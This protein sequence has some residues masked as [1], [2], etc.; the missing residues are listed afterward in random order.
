MRPP[1]PIADGPPPPP[2]RSVLPSA[3]EP[4]P[5]AP[6]VEPATVQHLELI[7]GGPDEAA[8]QRARR[9]NREQEKHLPRTGA[10][11]VEPRK[12]AHWLKQSRLAGHDDICAAVSAGATEPPA[13]VVEGTLT[14]DLDP[15]EELKATR[16]A[17]R[18]VAPH[19]PELRRTME[20]T[21]G[22]AEDP[23]TPLAMLRTATHEL[24]TKAVAAGMARAELQSQTR[25]TLMR[26]RK[27]A[28]LNILGG[29]HLVARLHLDSS[30]APW[31]AYVP[32]EAMSTLPL[33]PELPVRAVVT[34]HARQ[35]PEERGTHGLK[36]HALARFVEVTEPRPSPSG[37]KK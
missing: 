31:V 22:L 26:H 11:A 8:I 9:W 14:F 33:M 23:L 18:R 27:H 37:N 35:D 28:E 20:S 30:V 4:E 19:H 10:R 7:W 12:G 17:L 24:I 36:L 1:N 25:D 15:A 6:E 2:R 34:V 5:S 16:A 21:E 32:K 3:P 29:D 13:R